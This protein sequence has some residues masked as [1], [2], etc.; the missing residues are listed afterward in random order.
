MFKSFMCLQ[1]SSLAL[2]EDKLRLFR[3][4]K[5]TFVLGWQLPF[6]GLAS[7]DVRSCGFGMSPSCGLT[8]PREVRSV[9]A[10]T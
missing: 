8:D 10:G 7:H 4:P 2:V 5:R 3:C 1:S 9:S 6:V